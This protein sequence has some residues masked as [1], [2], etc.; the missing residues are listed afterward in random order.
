[1]LARLLH[2]GGN[3]ADSIP[4]SYTHLDVYKRQGETLKEL[5]RQE[6]LKG[7]LLEYE[8]ISLSS[9]QQMETIFH[10]AGAR[11]VKDLSLIHI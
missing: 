1:M 4:V 10:A 6:G 2:S 8:G 9:A 11:V 5:A 7:I 3:H